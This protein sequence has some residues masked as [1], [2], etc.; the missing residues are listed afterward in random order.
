MR[1]SRNFDGAEKRMDRANETLLGVW[2]MLRAPQY[3]IFA[4]AV[5]GPA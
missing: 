2:L 5:S 3:E 1:G 4:G